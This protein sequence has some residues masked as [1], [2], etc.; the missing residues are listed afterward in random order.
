VLEKGREGLTPKQ[1]Q[2]A[3]ADP[4]ILAFL[5]QP[6]KFF[7]LLSR[8]VKLGWWGDFFTFYPETEPYRK[9]PEFKTH[10]KELKLIGY[11]Q[12][13]GWGDY[14]KPVGSDDFKCE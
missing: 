11:W 3:M 14:C 9:M 12:K 10:V 13:N 5:N 7:T 8:K 6:D 2:I 4:Y 1:V